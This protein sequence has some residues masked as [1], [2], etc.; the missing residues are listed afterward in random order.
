MNL[1]EVTMIVLVLFFR[2]NPSTRMTPDEAVQHPW[3]REGMVHK[4]QR[5][6]GRGHQRKHHADNEDKTDPYKTAAQ[7]PIRGRIDSQSQGLYRALK[8]LK[9]LKIHHCFFKALMSLKNYT[10]PV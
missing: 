7:P 10:Y 4:S 9:V 5:G 2:W 1:N 3:I 6:T 8:L